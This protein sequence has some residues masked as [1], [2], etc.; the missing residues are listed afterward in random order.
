M[1]A[2]CSEYH[3][4]SLTLWPFLCV[5]TINRLTYL[6]G[7]ASARHNSLYKHT[8][9]LAHNA[10]SNPTN[11]K[12]FTITLHFCQLQCC[13]VSVATGKVTQV[14]GYPLLQTVWLLKKHY[15]L[16]LHYYTTSYAWTVF[17]V[18]YSLLFQSNQLNPSCNDFPTRWRNCLY[19][20]IRGVMALHKG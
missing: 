12:L 18:G 3:F 13:F 11:L 9:D 17:H 15:Q 8:S 14:T 2:T 20:I 16:C 10:W 6:Q 4:A 5:D 1:R 7:P 19:T